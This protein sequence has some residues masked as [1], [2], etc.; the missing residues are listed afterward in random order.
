MVTLSQLPQRTSDLRVHLRSGLSVRAVMAMPNMLSMGT[1]SY[2]AQP[3]PGGWYHIWLVFSMPGV[4]QLKLQVREP[5][6]WHTVRTLF[7]DVGSAG[8]AAL[9]T[10]TP[11]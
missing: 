7:Y 3:L 9:L 6:G 5:R 2:H 4:T 10:N 1:T 8:T 11:R